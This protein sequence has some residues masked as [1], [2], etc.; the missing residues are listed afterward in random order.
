M[1]CEEFCFRDPRGHLQ[2]SGC[3]RALL[4]L[5]AAG[6]V[7][8]PPARTRTGPH[9]PQPGKRH[10]DPAPSV[11]EQCDELQGLEVVLVK[12]K[13][14]LDL[15][16]EMMA[17][18]HPRGAGPLVGYQLR[19]LV[20]GQGG[21]LGGLGFSSCALHI[22]DRDNW[23]GWDVEQRRKYQD[24]VIAMARFLI[25][26][27]VH[28]GNLASKVLGMT[29]RRVSMDF[30]D[31]YKF[32]PWL[33]ES[34]V[35]LDEHAGTCYRAANWQKVGETKGRGRQDREKKKELSIKAIYMYPL[36]TDFRRRIGLSTDVGKG[37]LNLSDGIVTSNWAKNEFGGASFID[38]RLES[39]L[40]SIATAIGEAPGL[41]FAATVQ[42][43]WSATK[44]YYRFIEQA[45]ESGINM[46]SI[47]AP[48]RNRTIRRMQSQKV[49]LCVQDGSDLNYDTLDKCEGLGDIGTNQTE[50]VSRGLHLHSTLALTSSGIPLGIVK[51]QCLANTF[52]LT[53]E[54]RPAH[55]VPIEEKKTFVWLDHHR[56]LGKISAAVPNTRIIDIC[57]RE[58]DMFELF[59]EYSRS[60]RVDLLVRAKHNRAISEE[61]FKLFE[62]VRQSSISSTL[63][64]SIPRQSARTKKYKRKARKKR[65]QRKAIVSVRFL[66]TELRAPARSEQQNHIPVT[67]INVREENPPTGEEPLEWFL[68]TTI[69][70]TSAA[71]AEQCVRWYCLRWRI[72]DWHRVL[73]SGCCIEKLANK[74]A[75]RLRRAIA[76]RL[77]IAWRIMLMT[78]LGRNAPGLPAGIMFSEVE[79]RVLNIYSK[80]K[81]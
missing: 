59:Q 67:I 36:V 28:C 16:V 56:D 48:H 20:R 24:H 15:W 71:D 61:P 14:D 66:S 30:Q 54:K 74:T 43:L 73:K 72:E 38:R 51:A 63:E 42:G 37:S 32:E 33:V 6:H 79:V 77:V 19:Y 55:K 75:E 3:H 10:L 25:R 49:V 68:L 57:D 23:I 22:E 1:V 12:T 62:A 8:L 5:E 21:L 35:D 26:P 50:I 9:R 34:F 41:A 69:H 45:E 76:I 78:L 44:A 46:E 2:S 13:A 60:P 64:V 11:P 17:R 53:K 47:L 29:T 31:C 80:K 27:G 39:R 81:A 70:I 7:S 52:S 65:N 58:G 4:E 18:E 40:V